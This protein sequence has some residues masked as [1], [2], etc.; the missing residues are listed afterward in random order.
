MTLENNAESSKGLESSTTPPE[1]SKTTLNTPEG[2]QAL[3]D[4]QQQL[5][6]LK[7]E[8]ER[9][10]VS[11]D[12]IKPF[13]EILP[14]T[15]PQNKPFILW[16]IFSALNKMGISI[17]EMK[18]WEIKLQA[19]NESM[20]WNN[21]LATKKEVV[22]FETLLNS[23]LNEKK[24]TQSDLQKALLVRTFDSI[25]DFQSTTFDANKTTTDYVIYLHKLYHISFSI[26][27]NATQEEKENIQ[28]W[29]GSKEYFKNIQ[30]E[31]ETRY[32]QFRNTIKQAITDNQ[33]HR[34]LLIGF[35]DDIY[36]NQ[37]SN[38]DDNSLSELSTTQTHNQAQIFTQL[39]TL[40]W[41]QKHALWIHSTNQG[42]ELANKWTRDPMG[43]IKDTI[44]NG[45]LHLWLVLGIIWAIFFGKKWFFTGLIGWFGIIGLWWIDGI[46][47]AVKASEEKQE[48]NSQP[49]TQIPSENTPQSSLST[50]STETSPS[51]PL[52]NIITFSENVNGVKKE[53][54]ASTWNKLIQNKTF[55]SAP[56]SILSIFDDSTLDFDAK[57]NGLERYWITLTS[58]NQNHY[59]T[60]F[61]EILRQKQEV[62]WMPE[63]EETIEEYLRRTSNIE[64]VQEDTLAWIY[65][66]TTYKIVDWNTY[67]I[68]ENHEY[69]IEQN[70]LTPE[71]RELLKNYEKVWILYEILQIWLPHAEKTAQSLL[72][73]SIRSG[74]T[75]IP[76]AIEKIN[77]NFT[78]LFEKLQKWESYSREFDEI[79]TQ[80]QRAESSKSI[81]WS[82]DMN[83]VKDILNS[84]TSKDQKLIQIYNTMRYGWWSGNSEWVQNQVAEHL[85]R[86]DQ[87]KD[88]NDILED[89]NTYNLIRNNN[90][91]ALREKL[92]TDVAEEILNA[93]S[94]IRRK[95]ETFR[96]KYSEVLIDINKERKENWEQEISVNDYIDLNVD[97]TIQELLKH[98]LLRNKIHGL[99]NRWTEKDSYVWLYA[100]ITWLAETKSYI[101]DTFVIADSNIDMAIDISG[102]LA[103]AVVSMWVGAI[104]ARWALAA[105]RWWASATRLTQLSHRVGKVWAAT[106]FAWASSVEGYAFYQWY[107]LMNSAIYWNDLFENAG[108]TKEIAKTIAFMWVLRWIS[109]IWNKI[110]D[111]QMN[112]ALA[113]T[114]T[115]KSTISSTEK[116]LAY[117][118]RMTDKV[119]AWVLQNTWEILIKWGFVTWTSV[120][121]DY[122]FEWEADWTWEEYLQAVMMVWAMKWLLPWWKIN[123]TKQNGNTQVKLTHS[124]Q[125]SWFFSWI[126]QKVQNKLSGVPK[127]IKEN[128]IKSL[129]EIAKAW[130]VGWVTVSL[131]WWALNKAQWRDFTDDII[132][133][134][135]T[136]FVA[137]A[138]VK[139]VFMSLGWVKHVFTLW[140]NWTLSAGWKILPENWK[141]IATMSTLT[142]W[143]YQIYTF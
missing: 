8:L 107:N 142:Y 76:D 134:F 83:T 141:T 57:K 69:L 12:F 103:L 91:R 81:I 133:R 94:K 82:S 14:Q 40:S 105:A 127:K 25:K 72:W 2:Q 55:T 140:K 116:V 88:I 111:A 79:W 68:W 53:D 5:S 138:G 10:K 28:N 85:L 87:F 120:W 96:D 95:Q 17:K 52:A 27:P 136:W 22:D 77:T 24:F 123:F 43:A 34:E 19:W 33:A 119:P 112:I 3:W 21:Y 63:D 32:L 104:A 131:I 86:Q 92:W 126:W 114:L 101:N 121:I 78:S 1:I 13:I 113:R 47:K 124:P 38:I 23:W 37:W 93:Y 117:V 59:K 67:L 130:S 58:E 18:D 84:N 65:D 20:R 66:T 100:N 70:E 31:N 115:Q 46:I 110:W 29:K 137:W 90:K 60:L 74:T 48:N 129:I 97:F 135:A 71:A 42:E 128:L 102:T 109:W 36:Y 51:I 9:G 108:N 41:E 7:Q 56:V 11:V 143:G 106:R 45:W 80:I 99:E 35:Y 39:N 54:L 98:T 132:E 26:S 44:A 49:S 125:T 122:V 139:V 64:E 73:S 4:S 75:I 15:P 62:I 89:E 118:W 6:K 61:T 50:T 30:F 16:G